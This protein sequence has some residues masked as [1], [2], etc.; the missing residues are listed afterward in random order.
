MTVIFYESVESEQNFNTT[1]WVDVATKAGFLN[2]QPHWLWVFCE[3]G[4]TLTNREIEIRVTVNDVERAY[5][6]HTP[7][8]SNGYKS[9]TAFGQINPPAPDTLY[10]VKLQVQGEN[11]AQTINV[12][13]IRLMVMQR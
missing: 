5:D 3:Y 8:K 12:R 13:R 9:F 6:H 7:E 2:D 11:T 10:T 4:G 1:T